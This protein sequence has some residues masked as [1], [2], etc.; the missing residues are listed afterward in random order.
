M[1]NYLMHNRYRTC[2]NT[3]LFILVFDTRQQCVVRFTLQLTLLSGK[4]SPVCVV[5]GAG[6]TPELKWNLKMV[7]K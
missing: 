1:P 6:W 4:D 2:G 7:A 5:S 3:D